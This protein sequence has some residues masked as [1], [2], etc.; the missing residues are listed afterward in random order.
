MKHWNGFNMWLNPIIRHRQWTLRTRILS[1]YFLLLI[2][3]T[4]LQSKYFLSNKCTLWC[5]VDNTCEKLCF[6]GTQVPTSGSY[7]NKGVGANLLIHVLFI[8]IRLINTWVVKIHQMY[9]M[10]K[11]DIVNNLHC[12]DNTLIISCCSSCQLLV[13]VLWWCTLMSSHFIYFFRVVCMGGVSCL[14][15]WC[16]LFVWV[17]WV[18]C[19]GGASCLCG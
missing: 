9:N 17:V 5:N 14:C 18:V 15:G 1:L 12:F 19:V 13:P 2:P 6:F 4:F 16:E 11:I 8:V 7:Y 10:Y 3:C